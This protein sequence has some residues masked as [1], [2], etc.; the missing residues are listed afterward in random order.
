MIKQIRNSQDP[1]MIRIEYMPGNLCNHRC[2]YCF[3]GSN[4]GDMPW[5]DLDLVKKNFTHLLKHYE[6][7]GKTKSNLFLVGGEPT[8]W[9]GITD[10][11]NHLKN[12]FDIVIE[13]STNGTRKIAWWKEN[14]KCFDIVSVSVHREYANIQHLIEVCDTLYEQEIFVNANVMIDSDAWDTCV[15]NVEAMKTS[16]HAWPILAK[17]IHYDGNHRYT[18]EQLSYFENG[19]KR[20]PDKKWYESTFKKPRTEIEIT[21]DDD[22][23]FKVASDSYIIRNKLN[24]FKGWHCNLGVDIIKIF[25]DGRIT[26]N[27]QQIIYDDFNLYNEDFV[28]RFHPSLEPVICTKNACICTGESFCN[29]VKLYV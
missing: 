8:L 12:N 5:P 26:G 22:T 27:C 21:R 17:I 23:T 29:K 3:P 7:Q 24:Y 11:C 6:S 20:Y 2:H 28:E 13:I 1:S 19:V 9:P 15:A 4:E 16:K 18:E 14:A 25:A 10:F